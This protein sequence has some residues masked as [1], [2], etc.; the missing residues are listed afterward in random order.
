MICVRCL[1]DALEMLIKMNA[2]IGKWGDLNIRHF[3][4]LIDEVRLWDIS[5]SLEDVN[6][7]ICDTL[8]VDSSLGL[9]A[10]WRFDEG[11]G[12]SVM[13]QKDGSANYIPEVTPLWTEVRNCYQSKYYNPFIISSVQKEKQTK[14]VA[15][16]PN[17][18]TDVINIELTD[19]NGEY[20]KVFNSLGQLIAT[21]NFD[22][23]STSISANDL[24][25]G[26]Y[27]L[28]IQT[29]KGLVNKRIIVE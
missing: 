19:L 9:K 20:V 10:Y 28:N 25:R 6:I 12:T 22:Q 18:V 4:G 1:V 16:F 23:A 13:N 2:Q 21:H 3:N 26:M 24:S 7:Q 27:L 8:N 29:D 5:L 15:V 14:S 11:E 17:P